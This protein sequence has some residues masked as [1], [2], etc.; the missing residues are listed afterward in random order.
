MK[1]FLFIKNNRPSLKLFFIIVVVLF[2]SIA[3]L[4][5]LVEMRWIEIP[6]YFIAYRDFVLNFPG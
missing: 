6:G 1:G 5:C 2:L 4:I 3:L